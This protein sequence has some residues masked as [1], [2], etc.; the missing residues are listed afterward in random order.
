MNIKIVFTILAICLLTFGLVAQEA[1]EKKVIVIK[2]MDDN[3]VITET[4]TEAQGVEAD[5]IIQQLGDSE[6]IDIEEIVRN[7]Q[8]S[9]KVIRMSEGDEESA[10]AQEMQ[11]EIEVIS[12]MQDG[13]SVD[14]YK[15]ITI[16]D[17]G[18][19]VIEWDGE[20]EMPDVIANEIANVNI[21]KT[22]DGKNIQIVVDTEDSDVHPKGRKMKVIERKMGDNKTPIRWTNDDN[23]E[24][25][26]DRGSRNFHFEADAP[27]GNRA[28]LGI[29]IEDTDEGV[30]I[31]DIVNGSAAEA[32]GLRRGD[33]VLKINNKYI[34]TS[35]GLLDALHPFNPNEKV[36]VRYIRDGKEKSTSATLKAR[37]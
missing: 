28:S 10:D 5:I 33:V 4:R 12:E 27:N 24:I 21:M 35:N 26:L 8:K 14:K 13:K 1:K 3:G 22:K 9:I 7:G 32:A 18:E 19:N 31:T 6:G 29:M 15:I 25:S 37:S 16:T 17:E 34:F 36:K 30:I 11:K 23:V 20:G 2:K